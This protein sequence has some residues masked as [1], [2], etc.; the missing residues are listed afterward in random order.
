I[1]VYVFTRRTGRVILEVLLM[2]GVDVEAQ[3]P[4]IA[5][6]R[7]YTIN[8]I[9]GSVVDTETEDDALVGWLHFGRDLDSDAEAAWRRV[10]QRHL[11]RVSIGYD[12]GR[13]DYVTIP[14]GETAAVGGRNF[15]APDNSD[16][17]VV[18]RWR[19]REV[20]LVVIPADARAQMREAQG[21]PADDPSLSPTAPNRS[22]EETPMLRFLK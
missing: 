17:R 20:S 18:R 5:D 22:I 11:R 1:H 3:T 21:T 16:L 14:A 12:Y 13:A 7:Q 15:T 4:L 9:V 19:L 6:H 8:S 10:E 2:D